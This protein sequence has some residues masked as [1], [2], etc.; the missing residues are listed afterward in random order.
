M[1]LV[2]DEHFDLKTLQGMLIK[3]FVM[4]Y[5][6]HVERVN[7]INRQIEEQTKGR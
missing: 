3:D 7:A 6:L 4:F 1:D 2:R 5:N